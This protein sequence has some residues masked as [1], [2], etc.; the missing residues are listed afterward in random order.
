MMHLRDRSF[1]AVGLGLMA[2]TL[3]GCAGV[4][5]AFCNSNHPE[6]R[7]AALM[8]D[9]CEGDRAAAL[10]LGLWF[11][12][13]DDLAGAAHYFEIASTPSSGMNYVYVPPAGDVPGFT[14]PVDAGYRHPGMAEAQYRL[15]LMYLEGRGVAQNTK[16]ARNYFQQAAEQDHLGAKEAL[17]TFKRGS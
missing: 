12:G 2:L 4:G 14:M 8:R 17:E 13:H 10:Q 15:G 1:C 6:P 3:Q 11:E 9:S 5:G 16:K 7:V